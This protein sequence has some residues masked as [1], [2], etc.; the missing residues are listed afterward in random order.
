MFLLLSLFTTLTS[1]TSTPT[2]ISTEHVRLAADNHTVEIQVEGI[3]YEVN[4]PRLTD[5]VAR[6]ACRTLKNMEFGYFHI[7]HPPQNKPFNSRVLVKECSLFGKFPE[8]CEIEVYDNVTVCQTMNR[9]K[10]TCAAELTDCK[11]TVEDGFMRKICYIGDEKVYQCLS[12]PDQIYRYV[13]P[14]NA[15]FGPVGCVFSDVCEA[16]GYRD[17]YQACGCEGVDTEDSMCYTVIC[18]IHDPGLR[19]ITTPIQTVSSYAMCN[20]YT[21]CL[22]GLD[23]A[24]EFCAGKK[25]HYCT[26]LTSVF[27]KTNPRDTG[28]IPQ[29]AMC[30]SRAHCTD[31]SDEVNCGHDFGIYCHP[32]ANPDV[33]G[34]FNNGYRCDKVQHCADG[35]DELNCDDLPGFQCTRFGF[36]FTGKS[37]P[38]M[39]FV[40][41]FLRC[42]QPLSDELFHYEC[43][44]YID[45]LNCTSVNVVNCTV[46]NGE[47]AY[48]N[49]SVRSLWTC[50][51]TQMCDNGDD[52]LGCNIVPG[53]KIHKHRLCD[54]IND[55]GGK[56]EEK[57]EFYPEFSCQ[58][59]YIGPVPNHNMPF[60]SKWLCDGDED[61]IDGSDETHS[62]CVSYSGLHCPG[63]NKTVPYSY[64]CDYTESCSE[65]SNAETDLCAFSKESKLPVQEILLDRFVP[66]CLPGLVSDHAQSPI[67]CATSRG[68]QKMN[69]PVLAVSSTERPCSNT[70]GP[71]YTALACND[72]CSEGSSCPLSDISRTHC[73]SDLQS[74]IVK[75]LNPISNKLENVFVHG[76]AADSIGFRCN[77]TKC[78]SKDKVCNLNDDCGDGSDE[79]GCANS[80]KCQDGFPYFIP[81]SKQC[82]GQHDCSDSSDECGPEC[83][84]LRLISSDIMCVIAVII[85]LAATLINFLTLVDRLPEAFKPPR[86]SLTV[87][88]TNDCLVNL[89]AFG[90][91]CIGVYL[92]NIVAMHYTYSD[93][94]CQQQFD[95]LT[96][97]H[98][99][100]LG[101]LSTFGTQLSL[102][103]MVVLGC[104]RAHSILFPF[105]QKSLSFSFRVK[106][107]VIEILVITVSATIAVIP[108]LPI[109]SFRKYFNNGRFY[110]KNT[111][112][113]RLT[114]FDEHTAIHQKYLSY[115]NPNTTTST[116]LNLTLGS[117]EDISKAFDIQIFNDT[118]DGRLLNFYGSDGVCIFKYIVSDDNT[119]L[120]Y[121]MSV[122][123]VNFFCFI[124]IAVSYLIILLS[125][126]SGGVTECNTKKNQMDALQKKVA[127]II[128][129]DFLCWIPFCV[130][131][132]LHATHTI[133]AD[134]YYDFFSIIFIPINSVFN[135]IIYNGLDLVRRIRKVIKKGRKSV[136]TA[137]SRASEIEE[138]KLSGLQ[139][140][141]RKS[142]T[143]RK[144]SVS[145]AGKQ[146][147]RRHTLGEVKNGR[148]FMEDLKRPTSAFASSANLVILREEKECGGEGSNLEQIQESD[149]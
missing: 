87:S 29:T 71:A 42:H 147:S 12:R 116:L 8:D 53:C 141:S 51:D 19:H 142:L 136:S 111:F 137:M 130:I 5:R 37:S 92:L 84:S 148:V 18:P 97:K 38:K 123:A 99:D 115:I 59:K 120:A 100:L 127:L 39:V 78:I 139:S 68:Y 126:R 94:Y 145:H 83:G 69:G 106:I 104:F 49:T 90:D 102:F 91:L 93:S 63:S 107:V 110:L 122:V 34:W 27:P 67:K 16:I 81:R 21:S 54:G 108:I 74:D 1:A 11:D 45:Q 25:F 40:P 146:K 72:I 33:M 73:T 46:S 48:P 22:S 114:T 134:P 119:Q 6:A 7:V 2:T 23:E 143:N 9:L 75:T 30:D 15:K 14:K 56:D 79:V 76:T 133:N 85:A 113:K 50:D 138:P 131:C 129:T 44:G 124:L 55:C 64:L 140:T 65:H 121:S 86:D 77:N 47:V 24:E 17:H 10:I 80:F 95:W 28:W 96:T 70:F 89:I 61:C 88:Y 144:Y 62:S 98:C 117:W 57:C 112:F 135:P 35:S 58:R 43:D 101:V 118:S 82:D 31:G 60:P 13:V 52:E 4:T 132:I 105:D 20:G 125:V 41:D 66:P 36:D 26:R 149:M 128:A 3:W 32:T 109:S 103:S